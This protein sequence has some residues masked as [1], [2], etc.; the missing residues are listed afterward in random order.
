MDSKPHR[1]TIGRSALV[2]I[3]YRHLG[4]TLVGGVLDSLSCFW[5]T[6][7]PPNDA[8]C[9]RKRRRSAGTGFWVTAEPWSDAR[10]TQRRE[11]RR[12][13]TVP[14]RRL[15]GRWRLASFLSMHARSRARP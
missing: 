7:R 4:D 1:L 15:G 9:T 3:P 10:F 5:V 11:G 2:G 12:W 13:P 6:P 14:N 8:G